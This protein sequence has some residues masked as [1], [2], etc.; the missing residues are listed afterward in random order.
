MKKQL[1]K[2]VDKYRE[3]TD[4]VIESLERGVVPWHKP[5]GGD[6]L[7]PRNFVSKRRYSGSNVFLLMMSGYDAP[8]WLTFNQAKAL[9]G[10]VR[11]GERATQVT[12]FRFKEIEERDDSGLL[13]KRRI[14][15]LGTKSVFNIEQCEGI[16]W[17]MP[18]PKADHEPIG[19]AEAIVADYQNPPSITHGGSQAFYSPMSDKVTVPNMGDFDSPEHYYSTL[20]HE[21][22]HSTGHKSRLDRDIM[23]SFGNEKY[24]REELVAEM[25]AMFLCSECGIDGVFD[26]SAAYIGSWI[27]ALQNDPKMVIWA[28]GRAQKA[29]DHIQG[30][31]REVAADSEQ[32]PVAQAA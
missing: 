2:K 11:K 3:I 15:I 12:F 18:K 13:V 1:A 31:E 9:G 22:G 8:Y 30:I 14:P 27:Q 10:S 20:F 4:R 19:A 17:E 23:N 25:T 29:A 28:A 32:P 7:A 6:D 24:S 16:E 21:M 26:N 5:F